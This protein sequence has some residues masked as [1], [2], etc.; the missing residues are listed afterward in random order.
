MK[1]TVSNKL[2]IEFAPDKVIST[3]KKGL[4]IPNPAFQVM[5]RKFGKRVYHM[6]AIKQKFKY[7]EYDE[8][9]DIFMCGRGNLLRI[10]RYLKNN[11]IKY[12]LVRD[13]VSTDLDKPLKFKGELRDYQGG[14]ADKIISGGSYGII[15]LGTGYGKTIIACE[16]IRKLNK[17]ALVIVPRVSLLNQFKETLKEFY[18][19]EAGIIQGKTWDIKDITV[20]SMATLKR[21][22]KAVYAKLFSIVMADEAH[23]YISD[24]GL[25]VLHSFSPTY[26]YGLTAT[27]KRSDGQGEAI[28]YTFGPILI[29]KKLPQE[30]PT[31]QVVDSNVEILGVDYMDMVED[32]TF[33][34]SRNI[35]IRNVV[36]KEL[37][38]RRK[39]LILTKRVK[40]F[41]TIKF[42]IDNYDSYDEMAGKKH[43]H[44][45]RCISSKTKQSD[46][47]IL[48][49]KLRNNEEDF[50][51]I[52]GTYSMLSTGVDIPCLDTLIFAG[53]L[54][55][56]VLAEQSIGRILRIFLGKSSPKIIDIHDNLHGIF[57]RQFLAR[58]KFY[59]ENN[60]SIA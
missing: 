30:K 50:D 49:T 39:I 43:N 47:D 55:S 8:V 4:E 51:I 48:L 23:T 14:I 7:Y 5:L 20:A 17:T 38:E 16:I 31:V 40:H 42:I 34:E 45:I 37:K 44:I 59:K 54:K 6:K 28:G 11:G 12:E 27:P 58:K 2:Y 19:Y 1:I 10:H 56:D 22:P 25:K 41:E 9:N 15:K 32:M 24:K 3:L 26:L 13:F 53:D 21:R 46:R 36:L 35:L 29:D 52:L 33:N 60:W 57:H 18:D